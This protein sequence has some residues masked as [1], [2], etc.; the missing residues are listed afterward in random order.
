MHVLSCPQLTAKHPH[1]H[2]LIPALSSSIRREKKQE[3]RERSRERRLV[4]VEG[5]I[6]IMTTQQW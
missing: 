2:S 3:K 1:S 5:E 4:G 6:L